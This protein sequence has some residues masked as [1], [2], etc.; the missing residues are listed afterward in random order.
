MSLYL[1]YVQTH[2]LVFPVFV[3]HACEFVPVQQVPT[4]PF[5]SPISLVLSHTLPSYH[6]LPFPNELSFFLVHFQASCPFLLIQFETSFPLSLVQFKSSFFI[7]LF[8]SKSFL[9]RFQPNS[10]V[11]ILF[12]HFHFNSEFGLLHAHFLRL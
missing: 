8:Q 12:S 6:F 11:I 3:N 2:P 5:Q 9:F 10:S 1:Q 7:S 4:V